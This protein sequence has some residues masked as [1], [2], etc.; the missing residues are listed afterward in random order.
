M[1]APE[2]RHVLLAVEAADLARD[3]FEALRRR[4]VHVIVCWSGG[5]AVG[6]LAEQVSV[7]FLIASASFPAPGGLDLAR[8][9]LARRPDGR[10]VILGRGVVQ[11]DDGRVRVLEPPYEVDEVVAVLRGSQVG[12]R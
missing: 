9:F 7:D 10:V 1:N 11:D 5:G 6:V 3:L 12:V 8:H 2:R 4:D